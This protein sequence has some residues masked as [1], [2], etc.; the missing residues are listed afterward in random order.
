MAAKT[1]HMTDAKGEQVPIAYVKPYDRNRDR[2][3]RRILAKWEKAR[4]AVEKVYRETVADIEKIE[5]DAAEGRKGTRA[6]GTRGNFQFQS[7]DGLIQISRSARYDIRFDERFRVAQ[8][9][10]F[11]LVDEKAVAI[12]PDAAEMLREIFRPN[13]DGV[14]SKSKVLGLFRW[15]VRHPRWIEAMDLIRESIESRRGKNLLRVTSKAHRDADWQNVA[16]DI[17]AVADTPEGG[18]A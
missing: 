16:I 15:K 9:I 14:L 10:I 8:G 2:A 11:E 18:E 12:D 17:A 6:L 7:F 5:A 4:A 13:S 3:A 1:T